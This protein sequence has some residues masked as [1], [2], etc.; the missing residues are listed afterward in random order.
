MRPKI[1]FSLACIALALGAGWLRFDLRAKRLEA[2]RALAATEARRDQ[3][4]ADIRRAEKRTTAATEERDRAQAAAK[5]AATS[6]ASKPAAGAVR[7]PPAGQPGA[8]LRDAL[9]NDPRLQNL[10]LAVS[11]A[12]LTATYQPLSD[13][14]KLPEAQ[15]AQFFAALRKR[16][17]AEFD[18]RLTTEAQHLNDKDP[19]VLKL[20]QQ[21]AD[22]FRAAGTAALG[23]AGWRQLE[24][25]ERAVPMREF[26]NEVAGAMAINGVVLTAGQGDT[27]VDVLANASP[28]YRQGGTA[29]PRTIDWDMALGNARGVLTDA[30]FTLFRNGVI[31]GRNMDRIRELAARK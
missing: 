1:I 22:E 14:L 4:N 23:E 25:Y 30:Q 10:Q 27:L 26:V 18:L 11:Q 8:A 24:A 20:R 28:A 2:E 12:K 31:Q 15:Q 5:A 3:V 16:S 7:T 9:Q 21:A 13:Q 6:S 17:E 19:V 29:I